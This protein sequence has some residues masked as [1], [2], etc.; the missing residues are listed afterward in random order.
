[1]KLIR[2]VL[3]L[4]AILIAS[5]STLLAQGVGSIGGQVTDSLGAIV[6]GA[7]VTAVAADGK[8]K[9]VVT[10][11]RGDFTITGLAPGK[12]TVKAIAPKFALYENADV[13]VTAGDKSDLI[14]VLT[15]AGLAENV[16]VNTGEQVSTD[17]NENKSATVLKD[18][19]LEALPDDP[20]ELAAALQAMAGAGAGPDGGQINID[21]FAGGRMPPKEAI[22]EI[23]INQNPFSAEYDRIGFGRIDILTKPGFDKWRGSVDFR[24]NDESLNSR[25]PF[26][27]N[28]APSQTRNFGGF[29]SGPI[30]AKKSSF[31]LD[32]NQSSN[33]QNAVIG[34]DILT[35][36]GTFGRVDQ[37][38]RVPSRRLSISPRFD[39]AIND[40]NTLQARYSFS[41]N[42]SENQGV[43]GFT[44][45]SRATES[46]S[47][48]HTIQLTES[49]I[50]N[51]KTVNET[52][53]QYDYQNRETN[54][55]TAGPGVNVSG[56]FFGGGSQIGLNFSRS[57][58]WELQNYTT[59]S[60]GK[61]SQH[62]IKFGIRIRGVKIDDRSESNYGGTFTF[63]GFAAPGGDP[64]DLNTDL[65]VSS[66]EQYR[67]KVLGNP[68][69]KYNPTQ[70]SLTAGNP[71]AAVT[72]I[73]Y[74][75]FITDDWKVRQDLT[76]SF[77]LR[78][79]NQ[80]NLHSRFNFAPRFGFAW[81][82]GAGGAK[83][84]KTVF[85][86]GGG[87]FYD[88]FSENQTLRAQRQDGVTQLQYLV[89]N[90][91]AVLGQAVFNANGTVTNVPTATLLGAAVPLSSIPYRLAG[92]L[93]APYSIQEAVS[94]ERQLDPRTVL[95]ATYTQSRSL[96]TLRVRN[97]NAPVCPTV[98]VCPVGLT[99]AQ[100]QARRPDPSK[101]NVYQAESS[102]YAD[103]KMLILNFRTTLRTK[104]TINA[105]YTLG[106]ANGDTDSLSSPRFVVNTVGFPAYSYDLTNEYGPSAFLPRHSVFLVGS[107]QLPW[108]IRANPMIIASTGRRFNITNGVDT[109]Y[110]SLFFE[111]P[112]FAQLN[113]R[114]T[115]LGLK[116]SFCDIGGISDPNAV[117]PRNYGKGPGSFITN[118]SLNKTFGFGGST[119]AVASN[120]SGGN[121]RG[122]RGGGGGT[123][124]GGGGAARGGGGP[125]IVA[126]GGG[127]G[128]P[129][130]MMGGGGDARK[131]YQLTVG[132][133]VQNLF[134]T[135]NFSNPVSS[136]SSPSFGQFRSTG[137][138]FGPFGGG[139]GSANRRVDLSLRFSF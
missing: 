55:T 94:V 62:A 35:P 136:L 123:R 50:I 75:P 76:L 69:A 7:T 5:S 99:Q 90:N 25:N 42:T 21:G 31:F 132:I 39:Y 30:S 117:I 67:C 40:K 72:Q 4:G 88:R 49:M 9:Q 18:K 73:D 83:A 33:D 133:N 3:I 53:F 36:A 91:P 103:A 43:G 135:V 23:R 108:G 52:R 97:I 34:A 107:L 41:R 105:G 65:F 96:H 87:V 1:M 113:T 138:G 54:G 116:N 122:N 80:T 17:P 16:D 95:S 8:Q 137:G 11:S 20:D 68:D 118:L 57:K 28:R 61:Q 14:V 92:N 119:P 86:G 27:L 12:Y 104:Y 130:M 37:E 45:A 19:D 24:F 44:L 46:T 58:R 81:S 111:R 64:C 121:G 100:I 109:N 29:L 70:F 26:A 38:V 110:D 2:S 22:R 114:C 102:G 10:T 60:L 51:P 15:V 89:T 13:D 112:T 106:A 63:A 131:P 78:Y 79:E 128:G 139:G 134:N 125:T 77:G 48:Q 82:P 98:L 85:R 127:G 71:L 47:T 126:A 32:F 115:E 56:S 6:V 59:T 93:E 66:L 120:Q 84:P 124:G 129:M 101:G 74:S